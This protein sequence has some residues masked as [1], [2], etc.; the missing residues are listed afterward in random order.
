[1]PIPKHVFQEDDALIH[2]RDPDYRG[3]HGWW[4]EKFK[5]PFWPDWEAAKAT[6]VDGGDCFTRTIQAGGV[7][8]EVTMSP[9]G[10]CVDLAEEKTK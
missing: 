3:I 1:M 7:L 10:F 2:G 5:R 9:D 8:Y 4:E 6:E